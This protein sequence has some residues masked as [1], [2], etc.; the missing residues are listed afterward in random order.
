[1]SDGRCE[2]CGDRATGDAFGRAVCADCDATLAGLVAD[3]LAERATTTEAEV[4]RILDE[5]DEV[6][7]DDDL[8]AA[9]RR[10]PEVEEPSA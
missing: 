3:A 9:I 1:V 7:W 10:L 2:F 4:D 8:T 5:L 6:F